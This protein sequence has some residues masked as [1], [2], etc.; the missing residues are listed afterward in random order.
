M[1]AVLWP[2]G[3]AVRV[4]HFERREAEGYFDAP[5]LV[6]LLEVAY[7]SDASPTV[8]RKRFSQFQAL[9]DE[10]AA[11]PEAPDAERF[12]E[13]PAKTWAGKAS[14]GVGEERTKAFHVFLRELGD[15]VRSPTVSASWKA[16]ARPTLEKF[17]TPPKASLLAATKLLGA[18]GA[19]SGGATEPEPEPEPSLTDEELQ[20]A[21]L[22]RQIESGAAMSLQ[23][24]YRGRLTRKRKLEE[25]AAQ[26]Q[27]AEA[28]KRRAAEEEQAKRAAEE[29]QERITAIIDE[30]EKARAAKHAEADAAEAKRAAEEA[31]AKREREE[32]AAKQAEE[33]A[34]AAL[35]AKEATNA[36]AREQITD[37]MGVFIRSYSGEATLGEWAKVSEWSRDTGGSRDDDGVPTRAA[38]GMWSELWDAA[39]A[40]VAE[41]EPEA[42]DE[43]AVLPESLDS[44]DS[45]H[46]PPSFSEMSS[47]SDGDDAA[48]AEEV[49]AGR[50]ER[51]QMQALNAL[52]NMASPATKQK[53]DAVLGGA[54]AANPT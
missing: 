12:P 33:V 35:E 53:A 4:A 19:A 45:R 43:P 20:A 51:L 21:A 41:P 9:V 40:R 34:Q 26:Q 15:M 17:L 30:E 22:Q 2:A 47:D 49:A 6:Y 16:A 48:R 1:P 7:M 37:D 46:R 13:L 10:L 27:E 39:L 24:A 3:P 29:E 32:A 11:A 52:A 36:L 25:V 50:T 18:F 44:L 42:E 14:I 23:A 28:A 38:S 5:Y 8:I 54:T 31:A